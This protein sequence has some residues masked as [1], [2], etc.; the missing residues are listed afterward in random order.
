MRLRVRAVVCVKICDERAV[1]RIKYS[2]R[3]HFIGCLGAS[4]KELMNIARSGGDTVTGSDVALDGHNAE[5]VRGADLVVYSSAISPDNPELEYARINNI[6]TESR[7]EFLGRISKQYGSV[8]AVAGSHGKTTVTAMLGCIFAPLDATVHYGGCYNGECGHIGGKKYFITEACEY[9]RNFLHLLPSISVVLNAELD[10][11]DYYRDLDDIISAFKV[12]SLSGRTR[13]I[14]GDDPNCEQLRTGKFYTFGR[15]HECDFRAENIVAERGGTSFTLIAFG[16]NY[17]EIKLKILG[18]HNALNALAAAAAGMLTGLNF[19]YIK[20]GLEAFTGVSRRLELLKEI[21]GCDVYSDY[22]HHPREIRGTVD[23]L[24]AAGY[25]KIGVAFEPHTYSRTQTLIDEFA[26]AL[27]GFDIIYLAP[28]Y[29]AREQP[30][31]GVSS[32]LLS[33][34]IIELGYAA[35]CYDTYFELGE[36]VSGAVRTCDAFVF[37]GAGSIDDL[38]R[39]FIG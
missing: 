20:E 28:I 36:A 27:R 30:L 17:G 10:H 6:K 34:R 1:R 25:K 29:A 3:I 23:C 39:K 21:Y 13:L 19:S 33:R 2:M 14:C 18:E 32:Q 7:A 16:R 9:K 37:C 38:A 24:R 12:F 22:A 4:M 31:R 5:F 26:D 15:G 35:R 8:I 11:T